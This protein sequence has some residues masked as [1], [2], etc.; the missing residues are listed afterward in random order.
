[1]KA[2]KI[3]KI[4][5]I[6]IITFSII[7][8]LSNNIFSLNKY[9]NQTSEQ[10]VNSMQLSESEP[11]EIGSDYWIENLKDG[12]VAFSEKQ[13]QFID[14][15]TYRWKR[16][17]LIFNNNEIETITNYSQS[18]IEVINETIMTKNYDDIEY[19]INYDRTI[20]VTGDE[21]ASTSEKMNFCNADNQFNDNSMMVISKNFADNLNYCGV[22]FTS[23]IEDAD[24]IYTNLFN[25][26]S[27]F[28][29]NGKYF[30]YLKSL[31]LSELQFITTNAIEFT[32]K[33][34]MDENGNPIY[35]SQTMAEIIDENIQIYKIKKDTPELDD[36][37]YLKI[38]MY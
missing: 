20:N 37:H 25:G 8:L 27:V 30:I 15:G 23:I 13:N 9:I 10:I 36:W 33:V 34:L 4:I 19:T 5:F 2:K 38:Y 32:Q 11:S 6:C 3:I 17:S 7:G 18:S 35:T 21:Y 1:M 12:K 22:S 28:S 26:L 31:D 14:L 29:G 24:G 16:Y